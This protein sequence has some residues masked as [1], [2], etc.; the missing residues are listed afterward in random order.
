MNRLLRFLFPAILF[1]LSVQ[2]QDV[3]EVGPS[4][5]FSVPQ[6]LS[7]NY[8]TDRPMQGGLLGVE[9]HA[10]YKTG[11]KHIYLGAGAQLYGFYFST[12]PT[13]NEGS[14]AVGLFGL[15]VGVPLQAH[16][17]IPA[18]SNFQVRTSVGVTPLMETSGL[19]HTSEADGGIRFNVAPNVFLGI[20]LNNRTSFGFNW[21][22]P[23]RPYG[24]KDKDYSFFL[25]NITFK[26]QYC[27]KN[28]YFNKQQ[29]KKQAVKTGIVH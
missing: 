12:S 11:N 27:L 15:S 25:H 24:D 13:G 2:A 5:G 10:L 22:M 3:I 8:N 26:M 19:V 18:G 16:F 6:I 4:F 7:R 28:N 1:S 20:L 17:I 29:K 14:A 9:T 21:F 23:L